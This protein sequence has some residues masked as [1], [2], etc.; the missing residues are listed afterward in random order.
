MP[1]INSFI[2]SQQPENSIQSLFD[3]SNNEFNQA[4]SQ[5]NS[6]EVPPETDIQETE[7]TDIA[8]KDPILIIITGESNAGGLARNS[9]A[10][11]SELGERP[12]IQILNNK[13][14]NLENLVIDATGNNILDHLGPNGIPDVND[15]I[16]LQSNVAGPPHG[17]ELGLANEVKTGIL[18]NNDVYLCKIGMGGST[19][20]DWD[21]GSDTTT[22]YWQLFVER[23]NAAKARIQE[24]SNTTSEPNIFICLTIG[25]NDAYAFDR[26][27]APG[28]SYENGKI[29]QWIETGLWQDP[30][31]ENDI[32]T[33][34]E[35]LQLH[36]ENMRTAVGVENAPVF[37]T[38]LPNKLQGAEFDLPYTVKFNDA[39]QQIAAEDSYLYW[40]KTSDCSLRG[41][42]DTLET[43][44]EN[45][46]ERDY[47]HWDY[48]GNKLIANRIANQI[49]IFGLNE[50]YDESLITP[51]AQD[52][53]ELPPNADATNYEVWAA[54]WGRT[55]NPQAKS[56]VPFVWV[57]P[58]G[59][60]IGPNTT[61]NDSYTNFYHTDERFNQ[62]K[63]ALQAVPEGRRVLQTTFWAGAPANLNWNN[64]NYIEYY[65]NLDGVDVSNPSLRFSVYPVDPRIQ[66]KKSPNTPW[67]ESITQDL[68]ISIN[69][70]FERCKNQGLTFNY[71]TDNSVYTDGANPNIWSVSLPSNKNF[72]VEPNLEFANPNLLQAIITDSRFNTLQNPKNNKT[73]QQD[74]LSK[75][76][77]CLSANNAMERN[78]YTWYQDSWWNTKPN[79][80]SDIFSPMFGFIPGYCG[81]SSCDYQMDV[82]PWSL[83]TNY[84]AT[85]AWTATLRDW[86][87]LYYRV[88]MFKPALDANNYS[89]VKLSLDDHYPMSSDELLYSESYALWAD[90]PRDDNPNDVLVAPHIYGELTPYT[91]EL[92]GYKLNPVTDQEKYAFC[93]LPEGQAP[94][95]FEKYTN[96]AY[97]AFLQDLKRIRSIIRSSPTAWQRLTP[98]IVSP[99]WNE[100]TRFSYSNV[101]DPAGKGITYWKELV[102]HCCLHGV[103]FFNYFNAGYNLSNTYL[104]YF[105]DV[106]GYPDTQTDACQSFCTYYKDQFNNDD[107]LL[108]HNLLEEWRQISYNSRAEP[109]DIGRV[110]VGTGVVISGGKLVKYPNIY[111]WR[112]SVKDDETYNVLLNQDSS[113]TDI[114]QR[115]ELEAGQRGYWLVTNTAIAPNYSIAR[116]T[117]G[118]VSMPPNTGTSDNQTKITDSD[119]L[120]RSTSNHEMQ[121]LYGGNTKHDFGSGM[122]IKNES[123]SGAI[124]YVKTAGLKPQFKKYEFDSFYMYTEYN[125]VTV[126]GN[127][128]EYNIK[129]TPTQENKINSTVCYAGE[130]CLNSEKL[131]SK[132]FRE[133]MSSNGEWGVAL[134]PQQPYPNNSTLLTDVVLPY[135]E[136]VVGANQQIITKPI[137]DSNKP[138]DEVW[139]YTTN[140]NSFWKRTISNGGRSDLAFN[141]D[142]NG[143]IQLTENYEYPVWKDDVYT[144]IKPTTES[145]P[146]HAKNEP[147]SEFKYAENCFAPIRQIDGCADHVHIHRYVESLRNYKKQQEIKFKLNKYNNLPGCIIKDTSGAVDENFVNGVFKPKH[148]FINIDKRLTGLISTLNTTFR[149]FENQYGSINGKQLLTE[150]TFNR[151]ISYIKLIR[152]I[153][154]HTKLELGSQVKVYFND[155]TLLPSK[156]EW[157]DG[158]PYVLWDDVDK[159][160]YIG[161]CP[162]CNELLSDFKYSVEEF[163]ALDRGQRLEYVKRA[164]EVLQEKTKIWYKAVASMLTFVNQAKES[165]ELDLTNALSLLFP[166]IDSSNFVITGLNY[167]PNSNVDIILHN[168]FR[169]N[170]LITN[171]FENNVVEEVEEKIKTETTKIKDIVST[172]KQT[173]RVGVSKNELS[174]QVYS[175]VIQNYCGGDA[176]YGFY[177]YYN[178]SLETEAG[179]IKSWESSEEEKT[180]FPIVDSEEHSAGDRKYF[181]TKNHKNNIHRRSF[182]RH[183]PRIVITNDELYK[184]N[185]SASFENNSE[186]IINWNPA[187]S[188]INGNLQNRLLA[189]PYNFYDQLRPCAEGEKANFNCRDIKNEPY[190][191]PFVI[192]D[193][194]KLR[195][196]SHTSFLCDEQTDVENGCIKYCYANME[197]G[198]GDSGTYSLIQG[199]IARK[200]VYDLAIEYASYDDSVAIPYKDYTNENY[201]LG[202]YG[203]KAQFD[204]YITSKPNSIEKA[205]TLDDTKWPHYQLSETAKRAAALALILSARKDASIAKFYTNQEIKHKKDWPQPEATF[206]V[207]RRPG[208]AITIPVSGGY[209]K[210]QYLGWLGDKTNS[211]T[212]WKKDTGIPL[213]I[214]NYL[215]WNYKRGIRR[216]VIWAPCGVL[217]TPSGINYSVTPSIT[218]AMKQRVF[219]V[220]NDEGKATGEQI[221]NPSEACWAGNNFPVDPSTGLKIP[222]TIEQALNTNT[223]F[224]ENGQID[225]WNK[226]LSTWITQNEDADVGLYIGYR[227]PTLDG[228]PNA[229]ISVYGNIEGKLQNKEVG[230][231]WVIPD[232]EN[233]INHATFLQNELTPWI[234]MGIKF[235]ILDSAQGLFNYANGGTH[236]TNVNSTSVGD[237]KKWLLTNLSDLKTVI[238]EGLPLDTKAPVV[239]EFNQ[240]VVSASYPRKT[241]YTKNPEKEVCKG[242]LQ[243]TSNNANPYNNVYVPDNCWKNE[244]RERYRK[245][246]VD[247][248]TY[249]DKSGTIESTYSAKAYQYCPYLINVN[250]MLNPGEWNIGLHDIDNISKFAGLDPNE[251]LCWYRKN[252]EVGALFD[253]FNKLSET[254]LQEH[255]TYFPE[256]KN[257]N[258]E[259]TYENLWQ[260][261]PAWHDTGLAQVTESPSNISKWDGRKYLRDSDY[262]NKIRNEIFVKIKNY[263]NRGY[264]FWST[265]NKEDF[266]LTKD[267]HSDIVNYCLGFEINTTPYELVSKT[268]TY[269]LKLQ[270]TPN[271]QRIDVSIQLEE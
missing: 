185:L 111:V 172:G 159:D 129:I 229:N 95:G 64:L 242:I 259:Y 222:Q 221:I 134:R 184:H 115:I 55:V 234:Q 53:P 18:K 231:G 142:G 54:T 194:F 126:T 75:Y 97:A 133:E 51:P 269:N 202:Y 38:F 208:T 156:S 41:L 243:Q 47:N 226:Y 78:L 71:I 223:V 205:K 86:G 264:V 104:N 128:V 248:K 118:S 183:Y 232:P 204:P 56:I 140:S 99:A 268:D 138:K 77:A 168:T 10:L 266:Q 219:E 20:F 87:N 91:M 4:L 180:Q 187:I 13:T 154:Y 175:P 167:Y 69:D 90:S 155:V 127:P 83:S 196:N 112:I 170:A 255:R 22:G 220:Y 73:L 14:L 249:L 96:K 179:Y 24:L 12:E 135:T 238:A 237:Y 8:E 164:Q 68:K 109:V 100:S 262:Y 206:A 3:N 65:A 84:A 36:V 57:D 153:V 58:A 252:T 40:L 177:E 6:T 125:D 149:A 15:P 43:A 148:F 59:G 46:R 195:K 146:V 81:N 66:N 245:L 35:Q 79:N 228:I 178:C 197:S 85:R 198:V 89:N 251:M 189:V 165:D 257:E 171:G 214:Q 217:G 253:D 151:I 256:S 176:W 230:I 130:P 114:P 141:Y 121:A 119:Y 240:I 193:N 106:P 145:I 216:F 158:F 70:F 88:E 246:E 39:I 161:S 163:A 2:E 60:W 34:K 1:K 93:R 72:T 265:V 21:A 250:T 174:S 82:A 267:V 98:W 152:K 139:I 203:R 150:N 137:Y 261:V 27:H 26:S 102:Y 211:N 30:Y 239:N 76:E 186:I 160:E 74:F 169:K 247:G 131:T 80:P 101:G 260:L 110:P 62:F 191:K 31:T 28:N 42:T 63:N 132:W 270:K 123:S 244:G 103:K 32:N 200:W 201:W 61:D 235:L 52:A 192:H 105:S 120:Y 117:Q 236:E 5:L 209:N 166:Q 147:G 37:I 49:Q 181:N 157:T 113:R 233:N 182:L 17:F 19:V 122:D 9:Y 143:T 92:Y 173:A 207:D 162:N 215:T 44:K 7:P 136:T 254:L 23:V 258:K 144:D 213:F 33:W 225:E 50:K 116:N 218:G 224:D 271:R 25:I 48:L 212:Y 190:V 108:L 29:K 227:I 67:H 199:L 94:D 45:A 263:I 16:W 188:Y 210:K 124:N 241:V 11:T 107:T